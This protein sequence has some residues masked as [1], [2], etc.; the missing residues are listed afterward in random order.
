MSTLVYFASGPLM[1]H[2]Y[3]LE[4][5]NIYLVDNLFKGANRDKDRIQHQGKITCVGMDCLRSIEY[6]KKEQIKIDCFVCINEGL[7]EGGGNYPINSDMFISYAMPILN[8]NYIHIMN[9]NYYGEGYGSYVNLDLPF[10]K[11]EIHSFDLRYI[12][13]SIFVKNKRLAE[14]T[15]LFRMTKKFSSQINLKVNPNKKIVVSNDSIWNRYDN[16]DTLVIDYPNQGQGDYFDQIPKVV[17]KSI[18]DMLGYCVDN[19]IERV[20]FMPFRPE[21]IWHDLKDYQKD[22]PKEIHLY[23]LN[24]IDYKECFEL[25]LF[26]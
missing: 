2:F 1:E 24:F 3:N 23:H 17:N 9:R 18:Q 14:G 19:R 13:P 12:N 16:L 6:F 21:N 20:G 22:Y 10:Y 25:K 5:D 26:L 15:S 11:E 7:G 4:Y 8:D